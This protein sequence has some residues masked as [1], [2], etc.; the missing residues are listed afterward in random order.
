[1]SQLDLFCIL[2][3]FPLIIYLLIY[4]EYKLN[5]EKKLS[6][7][8]IDERNE[9]IIENDLQILMKNSCKNLKIN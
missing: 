9:E 2:L 1:M 6:N 7:E 3:N 4:K 5:Q 8:L